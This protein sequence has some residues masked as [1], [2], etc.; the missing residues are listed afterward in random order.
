MKIVFF[1]HPTFLNHQSMPRFAK[2]LAEGMEARHHEVEIWSPQEYFHKIPLKE[3]IKK[4]MG[5]I[6]QYLIFPVQV[7]RKK[8]A[9][10][11]ETLF[12]FTDH[13]LGPWVKLVADKPHVVHCHD[14][15][16]QRSAL[17][18]IKENRTSWTGR[19]Y[20]ALIRKGYS[21]GKNFISVSEKTKQDLDKFIKVNPKR[22]EVVYNGLNQQF[23]PQDADNARKLM[24][25]KLKFQ[26]DD[27]YILHVGGNQWYKNR[28]GV[29]EIYNAWRETFGAALP[30]LLVGQ[31]P[32]SELEKVFEASPFKNDIHFIKNAPDDV[33][34][35]A[36]CGASVFLF[37]SLAEGFGWP[38]AEAMASG[39][40]VITTSE[41]PMTEVAG[42]AA[43]YIPRRPT[44]GDKVKEWAFKA[45][46]VLQRLLA[47]QPADRKKMIKKGVDNAKRFDK[48]IAL[49]NI[50]QIY[51]EILDSYKKL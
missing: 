8:R 15:L 43:F 12:V 31:A 25:K 49:D 18:E 21:T 37:P 39:C 34:K 28:V 48:G 27:G 13:A 38:I 6:D 22:S 2:M 30:L 17:N 46:A 11:R 5:Y 35:L 41:A 36:Y 51:T 9:L 32:S 45:A 42:K 29:I 24:S 3:N 47:L 26:L 16:A 4:W 33:V 1:A 20:Q 19:Q 14:F 44:E 23:S 50:E 7:R 40:P 10:P